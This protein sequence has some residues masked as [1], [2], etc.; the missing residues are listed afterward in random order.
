MVYLRNHQPAPSRPFAV[1]RLC[2]RIP[3]PTAACAQH[4][5]I[6]S[7]IKDADTYFASAMPTL[8]SHRRQNA[9]HRLSV[10]YAASFV[11]RRSSTYD[12][13]IASLDATRCS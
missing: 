13:N 5:D 2:P 10:C 7:R 12:E 1:H 9:L 3:L 4:V 6:R 8:D 11:K